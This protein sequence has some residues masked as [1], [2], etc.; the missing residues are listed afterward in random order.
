MTLSISSMN[1]GRWT[2][3]GERLTLTKNSSSRSPAASH[4]ATWRQASSTTQRPRPRII[5]FSSA[6]A[7]KSSGPM[8]PRVGWRQRISAST[9]AVR[10][11]ASSMIGW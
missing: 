6:S 11:V 2:W 10:P 1:S 5:P 3:I 7:M 9:A 4:A 8:S